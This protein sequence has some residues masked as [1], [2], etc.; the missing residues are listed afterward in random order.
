MEVIGLMSRGYGVIRAFRGTLMGSI[1]PVL[2]PL[3]AKMNRDREDLGAAYLAGLTRVLV[4]AWTFYG[5]LFILGSELIVVLFG[6]HWGAAGPLLQIWA[7]SASIGAWTAMSGQFLVATGQ[8]GQ[9]ARNQSLIAPLRIALVLYCATI[10]IESVVL[11]SIPLAICRVALIWPHISRITGLSF[12]TAITAN[13]LSA[14][15]AILSVMLAL[16][17]REIVSMHVTHHP[18]VVLVTA[19]LAGLSLWLILLRQ[20]DNSLWQEFAIAT[21]WITLKASG[22]PR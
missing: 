3:F 17:V 8:V 11:S 21:R 14:V 7:L 13:R 20:L 9:L 10:S 18:A 12:R 1:N 15:I 22:S 4:V 5:L 16:A 19:L 6:R 2:A